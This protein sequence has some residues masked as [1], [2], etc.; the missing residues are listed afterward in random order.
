MTQFGHLKLGKLPHREDAR[1]LKLSHYVKV[2]PPF[3]DFR[4][5]GT[6]SDEWGMMLN[7]EL[8]CCTVAGAGHMMMEANLWSKSPYTLDDAEIK[9]A[10]ADVSG[11]KGTPETDNGA[12]MLD[13]LNYWRKNGI[14]GHK[15]RAFVQIEPSNTALMRFAI[16]AFGAV[17][18]GVDLCVDAQDQSVWN[19]LG[20]GKGGKHEPGSWG[21]HCVPLI[22]YDTAA[23]NCITWGAPLWMTEEWWRT[24]G[25]EAWAV[26]TEDWVTENRKSPGNVSLND[27]LN[28]LK[29]VTA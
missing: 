22:G 1:T 17:Y 6:A 15:I 26:I 21:G 27:L 29:L 16:D 5:W 10:Y 25:T 12:V 24:Y 20:G 11:W 8:G 3:P 14:G 19:V 9:K 18:S 2:I 4:N 23:F 7:D 28:D 13:V